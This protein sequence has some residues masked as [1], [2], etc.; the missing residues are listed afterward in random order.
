[1]I[2]GVG[3]RRTERG[4]GEKGEERVMR[5]NEEEGRGRYGLP[6]NLLDPVILTTLEH[7]SVCHLFFSE[8]NQKA[9][10][11]KQQ[12]FNNNNKSTTTTTT[13][14]TLLLQANTYLYKS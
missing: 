4:R 1:M 10:P 12:Q 8:T 5:D 11:T 14:T 3:G 2:K 6:A 7:N 13:T 9:K